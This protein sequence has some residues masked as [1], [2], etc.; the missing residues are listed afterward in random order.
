MS[1]RTKAA[2]LGTVTSIVAYLV[3]FTAMSAG[4]A[5]FTFCLVLIAPGMLLQVPIRRFESPFF[6][7]ALAMILNAI[8]YG[9]LWW[10]VLSAFQRRARTI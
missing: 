9:I 5:W 4:S 2:V 10:I 7:L 3:Q 6:G 8:L 1:L